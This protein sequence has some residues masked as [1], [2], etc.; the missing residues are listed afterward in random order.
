MT[1]SSTSSDIS[2]NTHIKYTSTFH[3]IYII[4]ADRSNHRIQ[5][6][7]CKG[8]FLFQFGSF[9]TTDGFLYY[10]EGVAFIELLQHFLVSDGSD[11]IQVFDKDGKFICAHGMKGSAPGQFNWPQAIVF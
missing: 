3:Q 7:D 10:P 9:G 1:V 5:V 8:E 6:F 11:H 4:V 2:L